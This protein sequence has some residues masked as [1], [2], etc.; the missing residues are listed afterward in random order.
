[1]HDCGVSGTVKLVL[2]YAKTK[3]FNFIAVPQQMEHSSFS[4]STFYTLTLSSLLYSCEVSEISIYRSR[5]CHPLVYGGL[6]ALNESL[7]LL[8]NTE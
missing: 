7:V 3:I 2:Y 8:F 1:M 6:K 4:S 5:K